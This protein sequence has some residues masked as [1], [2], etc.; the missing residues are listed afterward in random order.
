M[1][2]VNDALQRVGA[3]EST[4]LLG[5]F[6]AHIGTDSE[7][8]KGVIGGHGDPAF[9]KNG[10]YLLQLCC[11][12]G[13]C[14]VDTFFQHRDVHKYTWYRPSMAHKSLINFCIVSSDLVSEVL[15]V[16]VKRGP[17]CKLITILLFALYDFQNLG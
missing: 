2:D 7:T 13:L 11:S 10:R 8:W 5:D 1:D 12:N 3:T 14:I 4:I 16:Q 9:N 15:D 17:N 6:N